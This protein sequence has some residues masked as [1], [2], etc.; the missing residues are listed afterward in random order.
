MNNKSLIEIFKHLMDGVIEFEERNMKTLLWVKGICDVQTRAWVEYKH[1]KN[2]MD[3][4][5]SFS[6][7]HIR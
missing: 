2:M 1:S 6:L 7:E 3:L 4:V 5:G